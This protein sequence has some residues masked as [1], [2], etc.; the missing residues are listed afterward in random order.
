MLT[1][2]DENSPTP[3]RNAKVDHPEKRYL[4]VEAPRNFLDLD[5]RLI[6]FECRA[7][8]ELELDVLVYRQK[9]TEKKE[10]EELERSGG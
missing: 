7:L 8:P 3:L 10:E 2:T 9:E 1:L 5:K 6:E 4:P